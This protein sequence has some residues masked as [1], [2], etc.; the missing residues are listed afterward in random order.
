MKRVRKQLKKVE[1]E[2]MPTEKDEKLQDL[3]DK[4]VYIKVETNSRSFTPEENAISQ[5]LKTK[6]L[7]IKLRN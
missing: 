1:S 5:Y 2:S 4:I 3:R 7:L 6:I